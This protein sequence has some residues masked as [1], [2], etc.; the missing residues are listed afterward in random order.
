MANKRILKKQIMHVCGDIAS[1]CIFAIEYIPGIDTEKM[2]DLICK[3]A[4]LQQQT[5]DKIN[6]NFDKTPSDFENAALYNKARCQYCHAAFKS[7]KDHFNSNINDII[8][9]MN[10]LLPSQAREMNKQAVAATQSK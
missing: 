5:L 8:K 4:I 3:T 9:E 10:T 6:F 2:G 7:L 1:E